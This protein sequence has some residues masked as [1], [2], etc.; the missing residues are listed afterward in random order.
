LPFLQGGG[1]D[2]DGLYSGVTTRRGEE[3]DGGIFPVLGTWGE[4]IAAKFGVDGVKRK[5]ER[6]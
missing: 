3:G 1:C 4:A 5:E 6:C 2:A